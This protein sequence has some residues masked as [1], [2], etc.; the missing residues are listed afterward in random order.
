MPLIGFAGAPFTLACY[1]IEGGPSREFHRTKTFM[2]AEPE[3]WAALTDHL[4]ET[5]V[6]YLRAQ[7]DGGR[8][9]GPDLR[10]LGRRL[11]PARLRAS[12]S[13]PR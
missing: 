1:L 5:T 8:A 3:A 9:G 12:T 2:H 13:R 4:V 10:L 6:R 11:E 7:V